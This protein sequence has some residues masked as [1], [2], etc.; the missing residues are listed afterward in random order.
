MCR[1]QTLNTAAAPES[2]AIS[3]SHARS[4][5]IAAGS[6]SVWGSSRRRSGTVPRAGSDTVSDWIAAMEATSWE[7]TPSSRST[8][9]RAR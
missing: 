5:S 2:A 3:P 7:T 1:D 4:S 9:R 6:S 8:M